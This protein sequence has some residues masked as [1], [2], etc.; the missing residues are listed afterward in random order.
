MVLTLWH[1]LGKLPSLP[2]VSAI[3]STV[4]LLKFFTDY[5]AFSCSAHYGKH[6][7][8]WYGLWS[9]TPFCLRN[10]SPHC[11]QKKSSYW[12]NIRV[13]FV[14][15]VE[16]WFKH[17][18]LLWSKAIQVLLWSYYIVCLERN[19]IVVTV[20][21]YEWIFITPLRTHSHINDIRIYK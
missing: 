21:P 13:D 14:V 2:K 1:L 8:D 15:A 9:L 12:S 17:H 18:Y 20:A 16:F 7:F 3:A 11:L 10:I 5:I 19:W 6:N 4:Y